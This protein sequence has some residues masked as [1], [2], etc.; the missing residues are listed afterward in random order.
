MFPM[1]TL[2]SLYHYA[3]AFVL[4]SLDEGFGRTPL[5]AI[6]CGCKRIVVSDIGI[7]HEVLG[8]DVSYLP[9]NDIE[10][11]KDAFNKNKWAETP[12]TFKVPFDVLKDR[13]DL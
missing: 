10:C 5:E 9:L 1:E 11:C 2:Q 8:S 7:F 4:M 13:I 3:Y 12:S 6:A